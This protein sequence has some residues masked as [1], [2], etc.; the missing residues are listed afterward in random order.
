MA[1]VMHDDASYVCDSCGEEIVA[2]IEVTAGRNQT[3]VEDCPG[4]CTPQPIH[5]RLD[6]D[7]TPCL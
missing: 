7:G 5:G 6:F 3:Y 2:P 1:P 4:C